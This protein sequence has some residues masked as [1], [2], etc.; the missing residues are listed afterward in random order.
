MCLN[1]G[2]EIKYNFFSFFSVQLEEVTLTLNR[3]LI[4]CSSIAYL[5]ILNQTHDGCVVG[6][7]N[8]T[9]VIRVTPDI[10][11]IQR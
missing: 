4:H 10:V 8:Y 5:I 3:E 6:K 2:P 7:F 11:C 1:T 9:V